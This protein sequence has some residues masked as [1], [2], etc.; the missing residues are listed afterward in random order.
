[1]IWISHFH[2]NPI[3]AGKVRSKQQA[4]IAINVYCTAW[5]NLSEQ[6]K[7]WAKVSTLDVGILVCVM[8]LHSEQNS[9]T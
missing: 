1:V 3:L 4:G 7:T 6:D 8:Q 9:L 5:T 2:T